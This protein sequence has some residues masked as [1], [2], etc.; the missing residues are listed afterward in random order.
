[1]VYKRFRTSLRVSKLTLLSLLRDIRIAIRKIYKRKLLQ[2]L[3]STII[4]LVR[5]PMIMRDMQWV[6]HKV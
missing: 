5:L 2:C 3:R 1:M 4:T 6:H